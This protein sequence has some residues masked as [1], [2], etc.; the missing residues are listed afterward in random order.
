MKTKLAVFILALFVSSSFFSQQINILSV[1]N[2]EDGVILNCELVNDTNKEIILPL[3]IDKYYNIYSNYYDI[4]TIPKKIFYAFDYPPFPVGTKFPKLKKENL[5]IC[6]VN[7]TLKFSLNTKKIKSEGL[8]M[9]SSIKMRKIKIIY[10]PFIV[11][12]REEDLE[13]DIKNIQFYDKKIESKFFKL[14]NN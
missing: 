14:K 2:I 9:V 6:P 11:E 4:K 3:Q 8:K 7:T 5:L 13:E 12:N 1:E 10:T